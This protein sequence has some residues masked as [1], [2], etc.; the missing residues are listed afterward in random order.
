MRAGGDRG[1]QAIALL[2]SSRAQVALGEFVAAGHSA[3]RAAKL[4]REAGDDA[5]AERAL[6][7]TAVIGRASR[8]E[9]KRRGVIQRVITN[10]KQ[11]FRRRS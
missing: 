1:G 3:E 7:Q 8:Q 9:S 6:V 11:I 4:F 2:N 10:L 5:S